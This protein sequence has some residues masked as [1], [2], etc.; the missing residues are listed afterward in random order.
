MAE[1]ILAA[2]LP[3]I[4]V[5]SAGTAALTGKAADPMA[6]ELMLR[7]GLDISD[8]IATQVNQSVCRGA[9]LILVMDLE[10]KRYLESAYPF[11]RGKVFR[12][13]ESLKK[14][15]PD[16]Y[17]EGEEAFEFSLRLI[18]EGAKTWIERILKITKPEQQ[19]Q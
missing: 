2:E 16:P 8:H 17:R 7:R 11:T 9:E 15:V 18:E 4:R 13:A 1:G 19:S 3:H 14:D 5:A 12:I 10:Q 6:Q